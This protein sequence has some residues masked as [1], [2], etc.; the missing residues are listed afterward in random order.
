MC[1]FV[2]LNDIY[3]VLVYLMYISLSNLHCNITIFAMYFYLCIFL[4]VSILT[5]FSCTTFRNIMYHSDY[6]LTHPMKQVLKGVVVTF[7][8]ENIP[9]IPI[10][11]ILIK[12]K[13]INQQCQHLELR[14]LPL[15][16]LLHLKHY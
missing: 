2:L 3:F 12:G 13:V 5:K 8:L 10:L 11:R 16:I 4:D 9:F 14:S 15:I 7:S 1:N 6:I